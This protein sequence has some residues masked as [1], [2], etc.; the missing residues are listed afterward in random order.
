MIFRIWAVFV[1][2]HVLA[3]AAW[4]QPRDVKV[5]GPNRLDWEFAAQGFGRD[6]AADVPSDY[7]SKKQ[8]YQLYVPDWRRTTKAR[9]L[10]VFISPANTPI[11]WP[12]FERICEQ[13]GILF[14]SPHKA[15][16]STPAGLRIR[17]ILDMFDD[18]RRRFPIDP[19][20]TYIGGFS[21]G[22]R[23]ACS[24]GF[25]FPE[26]FAGVMPVCGTNPLKTYPYL[27][28]RVADRVSVALVT[29]ER[30]FNRSEHDQWMA[31]YLKE[32][33]VRT[34]FWVVPGMG[35]DIPNADVMDQV[36]AWL[37]ADL[38]RRQEDAQARPGL[39]LKF[40][41]AVR[42]DDE[43]NRLL[44]AARSEVED[45]Q[46]L[47]QGFAILLGIRQRWPD[48][49]AAR[50]SQELIQKLLADKELAADVGRRR[51][52]DDRK[53]FGAQ[54]RGQE[55]IGKTSKAIEIWT[56]LAHGYPDSPTAEEALAEVRRLQ[57]QKP[58]SKAEPRKRISR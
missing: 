53:S 2:G 37:A 26:L 4:A 25:A 34:Q 54:A 17:I 44:A 33:D 22:G 29:G 46:R 42:G 13:E 21:G 32:L 18:V 35:H 50:A 9:P 43:A 58:P 49:E 20:Q 11:G 10:I 16:N 24:I 30:D 3:S 15:G 7:D 39:N 55:R 38:K 45:K 57:D 56:A 41:E 6:P 47:W 23:M 48:S 36:V 8:K 28:H 51:L 52:E 12:A 14:C 19:N 5:S 1:C 27:R 40:N 31:P